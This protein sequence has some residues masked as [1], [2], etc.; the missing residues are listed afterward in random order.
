VTRS[1]HSSSPAETEARP[2]EEGEAGEVVDALP[3]LAE[4][5]P[6]PRVQRR[7]RDLGRSARPSASQM[8]V[9]QAAVVAA[10]GF[11]AGAAV[12]GLVNRRHSRSP[13][14]TGGGR[15]GRSLTRGSRGRA[16]GA[17]LMQIVGT[18]SFLVDVH[19]LGTPGAEH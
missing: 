7:A 2:G 9:V 15:A 3:V 5:A 18:R 6:G 4:E 10:G 11:V 16:A 17:E 8:P 19:L 14:L 12:V 13:A 1:A